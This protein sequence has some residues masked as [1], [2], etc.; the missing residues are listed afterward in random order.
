MLLSVCVYIKSISMII[1]K[2]FLI[3]KKYQI[4]RL[5]S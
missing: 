5:F 4:I 2:Y 1:M 3:T